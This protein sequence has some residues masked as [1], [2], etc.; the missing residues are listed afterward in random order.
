MN[1]KLLREFLLLAAVVKAIPTSTTLKADSS[2]VT[3]I[4][5]LLWTAMVQL[6]PMTQKSSSA[7]L[8]QLKPIVKL[9]KPQIELKLLFLNHQVE[10]LHMLLE[11]SS[12]LR[13]LVQLTR[14]KNMVW[15]AE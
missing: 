12:F 13:S 1:M 11:L 14:R 7:V 8:P 15:R 6:V 2:S 3:P 5:T 9:A 10:S 4:S